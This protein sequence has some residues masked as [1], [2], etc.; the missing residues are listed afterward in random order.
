MCTLAG[1]LPMEDVS[2]TTNVSQH[3]YSYEK[4]ERL[5]KEKKK[6]RT[7]LSNLYMWDHLSIRSTF[8]FFSE[9]RIS[10]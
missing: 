5:K 3:A 2:I 6:E 9:L 1:L 10:F 7:N 4:K 8:F